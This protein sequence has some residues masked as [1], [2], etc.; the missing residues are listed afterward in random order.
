MCGIAGFVEYGAARTADAERR[1]LTDAMGRTLGHRGPDDATG[2]HWEG[3]SIAFRRLSI[4]GI[5]AGAQPFHSR[6]GRIS[7][8]VNGELYNHAELRRELPEASELTTGSDCEVLPDLVARHGTG[9]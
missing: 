9:E 8:F 6:D 4:N 7:A 2:L 5:D 1:A 3:V